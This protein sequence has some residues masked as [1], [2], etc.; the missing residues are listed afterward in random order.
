MIK[1]LQKRTLVKV[2]KKV[3]R[4]TLIVHVIPL[5]LENLCFYIFQIFYNEYIFYS[6]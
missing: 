5:G 3:G 1:V 2:Q 4:S 6:N